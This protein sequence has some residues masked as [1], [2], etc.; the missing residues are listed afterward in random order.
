[1]EAQLLTSHRR[2]LGTGR[3]GFTALR[4][5]GLTGKPRLDTKLLAL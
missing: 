1:L 4:F 3:I 2:L 5:Q